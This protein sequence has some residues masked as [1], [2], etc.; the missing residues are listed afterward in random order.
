MLK[1]SSAHGHI[2]S[3][4]FEIKYVTT[5]CGQ[6]FAEVLD[7]G[8]TLTGNRRSFNKHALKP[9]LELKERDGIKNLQ[10][11]ITKVN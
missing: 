5:P 8:E 7:A 6:F 4:A 10:E 1:R 2:K 11:E 9:L 3:K